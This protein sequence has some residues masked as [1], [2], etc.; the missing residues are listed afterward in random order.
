MELRTENITK[1][2]GK[3]EGT[4]HAVKGINLT[5]NQGEFVAVVGPSGSGKSTLLHMLS[6]LDTPSE[7]KVLIDGEDMYGKNDKE[8]SR[9]RRKKFGFVF[10]QFNLVPALTVREN[11]IF[12]V[13]LDK[14]KPDEEFLNTL[15]NTLGIYEKLNCFPHQLSGG[16]Q[17]R[18][19]IARALIAKPE[20]VF[21]DEPTG[22]LDQDSGREVM[23]LL[24]DTTKN[25]Q[26]TLIVI[27]HDMSIASMAERRLR[28][29]DGIIQKMD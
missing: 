9:F 22:N 8:L 3:G 18:T 17:Q 12:P 6:G 2:Y 20:V 28:I 7:G 21:A 5:I 27:T 14:E 4:V 25:F 26:K 23:K 24:I 13:L 15:V 10:Q 1:V 16:Q 29:V 11:I 19:A